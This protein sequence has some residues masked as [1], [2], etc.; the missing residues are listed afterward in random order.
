MSKTTRKPPA[1]VIETAATP[2]PIVAT[3]RKALHVALGAAALTQAE[4]RTWLKRC[5]E[6]G[7]IAEGEVRQFAQQLNAKRH[8]LTQ[9]GVKFTQRNADKSLATVLDQLDIPSKADIEALSRK[10]TTLTHKV[11]ALPPA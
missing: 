6:R 9:R 11:D 3:S 10:I 2:H 4:A 5:L 8:Q 7:A 1:T